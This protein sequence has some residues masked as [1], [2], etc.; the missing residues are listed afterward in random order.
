MFSGKTRHLPYIRN[1]A[2]AKRWW[3]THPKPPRSK[4]WEDYQ[5]PLYNTASKHYRLETMS[6]DEYIDVV[7]YHTVMARYYKPTPDGKQRRLYVGNDTITSRSFMCDV[8]GV[9]PWGN[10]EHT[11]DGRVVV[12]PIYWRSFMSDGGHEFSADF[13]FDADNKLIVNESQ[14]TK[15]WRRVSNE[16]DKAKRA[17]IR[18]MF[19]IYLDLAMLRLPEFEAN[20]DIDQSAGRPFSGNDSWNDN[21]GVHAMYE[22]MLKGEL[23]EQVDIEKFF[24]VARSAFNTLASKRAYNQ[25][26]FKMNSWYAKKQGIAPSTYADLEK[27]VTGADLRKALEGKVLK[28]CGAN[29]QTGHLPIPQF[30]TSDDYPSSNVLVGENP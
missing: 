8:V 25:D 20:V 11:S 27:P 18:E 13:M 10:A 15:H 6:P 3:D 12:A 21:Q 22:A 28:I 26:G 2:E 4:R 17:D 1:Y 19:S 30:P 5:R 9:N 14:H 29:K 24:E 23:P 7:L 16:D